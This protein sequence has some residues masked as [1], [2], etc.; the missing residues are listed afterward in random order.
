MAQGRPQ[1]PL[2][3]RPGQHDYARKKK[4]IEWVFREEFPNWNERSYT[5]ICNQVGAS[6][7][8]VYYWKS[9]WTENNS[10]RP[11]D[12]ANHGQHLRKFTD[13]EEE[14]IVDY[15]FDNYI[16]PG[17]PMTNETFRTVLEHAWYDKY[18]DAEEVPD[19]HFSDGF[20]DDFKRRHRLSTRKAHL[21]RR[22]KTTIEQQR[23]FV[24][25]V[26]LVLDKVP[27]QYVLNCDETFWRSVPGDIRTWGVK[28]S[29]T[30]KISVEA[31]E[32][33]GVTV[34]ACIGADCTKH[35]MWMIAEGKTTICHRQ[36]GDPQGNFVTHSVSG[37]STEVTFCEFLRWLRRD[38]FPGGEKV[39]LL[40]DLYSVHRKEKVR[41]CAKECNIQLIYIPGGMTDIYQPLDRRVFGVMKQ[42]L[43]RLWR[44]MYLDD[45]FAVFNK[46]IAIELLVPC[47]EKVGPLTIEGAWEV[48]DGELEDQYWDFDTYP[49]LEQLREL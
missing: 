17:I 30:I 13:E 15:I 49:F 19:F 32:K 1:K 44:R 37:W 40:L 24:E 36:L 5:K 14:A 2:F 21:A 39:Y 11:W 34:L 47:W 22:P 48:F 31:D 18:R 41:D 35:P 25:A 3:S 43:R 46:K 28:G 16:V 38:R 4:E 23:K 45:P 42:H 10:W 7:S 27:K 20:I 12:P 29:D 6:S 9:K 33:E 8:T 26:K